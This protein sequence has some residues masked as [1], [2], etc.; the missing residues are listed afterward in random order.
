[1]EGLRLIGVEEEV[2]KAILWVLGEVSDQFVVA[3]MR[4]GGKVDLPE[5][6]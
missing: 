2:E 6:S 1:M 4:A 5:V 3:V